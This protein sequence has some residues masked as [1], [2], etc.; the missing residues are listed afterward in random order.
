MAYLVHHGILGQKWG[1]RRYQNYDGT[2]TEAGKKRYQSGSKGDLESIT[3]DLA[4]FSGNPSE[5]IRKVGKERAIAAA[6][7]G[8]KALVESG[9]V[10][11]EWINGMDKKSAREWFVYEDQT[12]GCAAIADLINQ[13][14]SATDVKTFIRDVEQKFY[15]AKGEEWDRMYQTY[16]DILEGYNLDVFANACERVKQHK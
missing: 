16:F 5:A 2:L 9:D 8:L 1:V 13:G 3:K 11:Q 15:S 6:D 12:I 4:N 14:Y 7:L 10:D